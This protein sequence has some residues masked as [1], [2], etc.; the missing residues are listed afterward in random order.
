M[1]SQNGGPIRLLYL[2]PAEGFGGAERQGVLHISGLRQHGFEVVPVVGPGHAILGALADEGVDEYVFLE[3]LTQ[4][5]HPP[6]SSFGRLAFATRS[7]RNWFATQRSIREL[8]SARSIDL[9]F[10]NRTTGWIAGGVAARELR[11]PLVWRGGSRITRRF[12]A[13]T[14]RTLAHF[15]GP[16]L[17]LVNCE[18]VRADLTPLIRAPSLLLHNGVDTRRFHAARVQPRIRRQLAIADDVPVIGFASRPAPEKGM[19]LLA[20]V[21]ELSRE[22]LPRSHFLVAGE[23]GWREQYQEM[24]AA[25]GLADRV[26]FLGHLADVE[27]F[28]RSCDVVVLTSPQHSIEGSPNAL[29]E[30]MAMERPIVATRVGGVAELITDGVEGYLVAEND[31]QAFTR[32]L[33]EL[34]YDPD[35]RRRMGARGR[36]SVLARF[37]QDKVV[38]RLAEVLHAVHARVRPP[39]IWQ[40]G[41]A[42]L[43]VRSGL[44]LSRA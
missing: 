38:A 8:A 11:V 31:A 41:R 22:R 34:V 33:V 20:R 32:R 43:D 26:R 39:A 9:V 23:F 36:A 13:I 10:A 35:L 17:L 40:P 5:A 30:A 6:L 12:E 37:D 29:I 16:D 14:L 25:R 28:L 21:V 3:H 7:V 2:Q 18:A 15:L 44:S 4:K 24:F 27:S 42:R 19:E 1:V